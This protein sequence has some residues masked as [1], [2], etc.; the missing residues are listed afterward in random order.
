MLL[1]NQLCEEKV[2]ADGKKKKGRLESPNYWNTNSIPLSFIKVYTT[3]TT[4]KILI[5]TLCMM[6]MNKRLYP[7][8]VPVKAHTY[9]NIMPGRR[10]GRH[11]ELWE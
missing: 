10:L 7:V 4:C 8:G 2:K 9:I 5:E 6:R 11:K 3:P 1:L